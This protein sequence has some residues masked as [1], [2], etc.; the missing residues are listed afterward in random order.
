M[1]QGVRTA[2]GSNNRAGPANQLKRAGSEA[3]RLER[4][5]AG[6]AGPW[7]RQGTS[8]CTAGAPAFVL[9]TCSLFEVV[10]SEAQTEEHS[11]FGP[12]GERPGVVGAG[13]LGV[14]ALA[15][16]GAE[17]AGQAGREG[18]AWGTAKPGH[19]KG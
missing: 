12:C 2:S 5:C 15:V 7:A 18:C 9:V 10:T 17:Q 19:G 11:G 1:V 8:R 14:R 16:L 6:Q 13:A 4:R 3:G